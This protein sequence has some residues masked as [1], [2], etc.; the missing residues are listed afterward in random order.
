LA[1]AYLMLGD[2]GHAEDLLQ[3]CLN[4]IRFTKPLLRVTTD[5]KRTCAG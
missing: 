1:A 5:S 2:R 3:T 4:P